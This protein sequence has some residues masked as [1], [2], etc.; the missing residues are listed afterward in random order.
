LS[1]SAGGKKSGF[2]GQANSFLRFIAGVMGRKKGEAW[3]VPPCGIDPV[4][5]TQTTSKIEDYMIVEF[6]NHAAHQKST[7][8]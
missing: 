3:P 4:R 2:S 5:I 7:I 8:M 6:R 1:C